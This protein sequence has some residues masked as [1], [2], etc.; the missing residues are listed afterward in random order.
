MATWI[1]ECR[2]TLFSF[3]GVSGITSFSSIFTLLFLCYPSAWR[4]HG[5]PSAGASSRCPFSWGP[6]AWSPCT[7]LDRDEIPQRHRSQSCFWAV[8]GP[9]EPRHVFHAAPPILTP[10]STQLIHSFWVP[11]LTSMP[12]GFQKKPKYARFLLGTSSLAGENSLAPKPSHSQAFAGFPSGS[13]RP[14]TAKTLAAAFCDGC[15]TL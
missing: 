12:T 9:R 4:G 1:P 5:V 14:P 8:P 15:S 2:V 11:R 3:C 6:T 7:V 10:G 13:F